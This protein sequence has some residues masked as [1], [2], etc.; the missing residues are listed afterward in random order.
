MPEK[1]RLIDKLNQT[2]AIEA[3]QPRAMAP[4]VILW[5]GRSFMLWVY[6]KQVQWEEEATDDK[7]TTYREC[8]LLEIP[9]ALYF[10]KP[11]P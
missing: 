3:V 8:T 5:C 4:N 10:T 7:L 1:I 6:R 11:R 2:V 9:E